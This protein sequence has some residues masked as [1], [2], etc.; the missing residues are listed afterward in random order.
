F[1]IT[2][3]MATPFSRRAR[4]IWST[5]VAIVAWALSVQYLQ[6]TTP[7]WALFFL[8]PLVP[9]FDR[10]MPGKKFRWQ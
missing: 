9:F 3:P 10:F 2:D 4:I 5:L 6:P 1:M 7:L 8:S